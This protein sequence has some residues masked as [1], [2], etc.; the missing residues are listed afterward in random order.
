MH[1]PVFGLIRKTEGLP[2]NFEAAL[3]NQIISERY[4]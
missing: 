4:L 1:G 2:A 3:A